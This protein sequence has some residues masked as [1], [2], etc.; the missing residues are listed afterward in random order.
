M[1]T[2]KRENG[3]NEMRVIGNYQFLQYII[4]IQDKCEIFCYVHKKVFLMA[5]RY[6]S[7]K[8]CSFEVDCS[9]TDECIVLKNVVNHE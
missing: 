8:P 9:M 3:L 2:D 7:Y 5:P 1:T 4:I 6:S